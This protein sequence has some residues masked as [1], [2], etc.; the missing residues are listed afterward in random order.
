MEYER[1]EHELKSH[2][3]RQQL[4]ALPLPGKETISGVQ[5]ATKPNVS[6]LICDKKFR[7]G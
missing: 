1:D 6:C 5:R 4:W 2:Q 3:Q 7:N